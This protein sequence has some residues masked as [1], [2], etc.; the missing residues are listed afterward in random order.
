MLLKKKTFHR[1]IDERQCC[2]WNSEPPLIKVVARYLVCILFYIVAWFWKHAKCACA[3][4]P[5]HERKDDSL[6][7]QSKMRLKHGQLFLGMPKC[8]WGDSS[9]CVGDHTGPPFF[10]R[11]LLSFTWLSVFG[12]K[13]ELLLLFPQQS[14]RSASSTGKGLTRRKIF[15]FLLHLTRFFFSL[16]WLW[17]GLLLLLSSYFPLAEFAYCIDCCYFPPCVIVSVCVYL[18]SFLL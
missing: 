11:S 1:L 6:P 7:V 14:Q 9:T 16:G 13:V 5:T 2:C 8:C 17:L 4:V 10:F 3:K 12:L 15:V 18:S